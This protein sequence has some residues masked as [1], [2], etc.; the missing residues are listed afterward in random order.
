MP[1][2]MYI[3]NFYRVLCL[4]YPSQLLRST[5]I[6]FLFYYNNQTVQGENERNGGAGRTAP[7]FS[8]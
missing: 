7:R 2:F 3:I 1:Q 4:L 5:A 8:C 6:R